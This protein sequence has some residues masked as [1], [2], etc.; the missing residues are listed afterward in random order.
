MTKR[1]DHIIVGAGSA[2]AVLAAR[3]SED[4]R[5]SVLLLEAGPDYPSQ[6]L[7]PDEVRYAYG[8]R[9]DHNLGRRTHPRCV[10]PGGC[11]CS[12]VCYSDSPPNLCRSWQPSGL[13]QVGANRIG[14]RG[15]GTRRDR[16]YFG[17]S[18]LGDQISGG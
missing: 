10:A 13:Q 4:E 16:T 11:M 18:G 7:T 12:F 17:F 15:T 1:Y 9:R 2:G 14:Y 5:R 8:G 6:N 3:L